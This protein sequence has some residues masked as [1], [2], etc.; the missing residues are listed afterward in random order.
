MLDR[1]RS[2][3]L[4]RLIAAGVTVAA[5]AA[6]S[7][8]AR[9]IDDPK[10]PVRTDPDPTVVVVPERAPA[11]SPVVQRIDD[12]VDWGSA[13]IGAGSAGALIVLVALGGVAY[14]AR[15]RIGGAR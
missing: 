11:R 6:P 2:G 14:T 8:L 7:A 9:P 13:A 3:R 1:H 4:A 12:G 5:F 15:H 10:L